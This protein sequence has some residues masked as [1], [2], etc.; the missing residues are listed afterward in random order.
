MLN[1]VAPFRRSTYSPSDNRLRI[2]SPYGPRT[3]PF[4]G[5]I[6]A[7]HNGLDIAVPTGT[8]VY[9]T[10]PGV[11]TRLDD[12]CTDPTNGAYFSVEHSDGSRTTYVHMSEIFVRE[13]Q[14]VG[15]NTKLALTGGTSGNPC[16]GRS[17]GP[18]L[19]FII[20]PDGRNSADPLPLVNW[21]PYT[22]VD[23]NRQ[24]LNVKSTQWGGRVAALTTHTPI[25]VWVA[26]GAAALLTIGFFRRGRHLREQRWRQIADA[27]RRRRRLR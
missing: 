16:S 13:G 26:V 17:T 20:R 11:V 8:P 5:G 24:P 14:R 9:P 18:H 7:L 15:L 3:N 21:Y 6:Q 1:Y 22:V 25:F 12:S 27:P 4:T 19:H 23:S 2:S 10:A